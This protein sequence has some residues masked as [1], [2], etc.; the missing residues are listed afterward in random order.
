MNRL[1]LSM[2]NV[3]CSPYRN[4]KRSIQSEIADYLIHETAVIARVARRSYKK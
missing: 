2:M 4:F 1:I 3:S